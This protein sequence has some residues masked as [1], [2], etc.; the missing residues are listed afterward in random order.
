MINDGVVSKLKLNFFPSYLND[1][2]EPL[3]RG[4][5]LLRSKIKKN[6]TI[7]KSKPLMEPPSKSDII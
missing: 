6:Y 5:L 2:F 4:I 3:C 7:D 1:K